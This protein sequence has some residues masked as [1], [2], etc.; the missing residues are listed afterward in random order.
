M[1]THGMYL[2]LMERIAQYLA[3][4]DEPTAW[5]TVGRMF[6]I[7]PAVSSLVREG[8]VGAGGAGPTRGAR[9]VVVSPAG[10]QTSLGEG[11]APSVALSEQGFYSVRVA[12]TG[13]RR[14]FEVAVNIDPTESDLKSLPPAE[15]L[16]G[17]TGGGTITPGG[18]SL[19]QA[20]VK[21]ADIEKKQAVW[22]FLL[23]GG[24]VALLA[25]SIVSNRL[26]QRAGFNLFGTNAGSN[27]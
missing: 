2:P 25:E 11:G 18:Q 4:Y 16:S 22:W 27:A 19:E 3:Q 23:V 7:S 1:P 15:F 6:D 8:Q 21:P 5:Q 26:S 17:A 12:G 13:E 9:G 14:P 24:L 10:E 20:E